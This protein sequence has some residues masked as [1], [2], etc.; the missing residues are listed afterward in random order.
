MLLEEVVKKTSLKT[1]VTQKST[2][3]TIQAFL[4][5]IKEA[6][7]D[8]DKVKL[9]GFGCFETRMTKEHRG[10]FNKKPTLILAHR[11]VKFT[12][13]EIFKEIV[14]KDTE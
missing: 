7:E 11:V 9:A 4:E 13:S 8:G 5:V 2:K 3:P 14:K 6:L 10:V 12:P 1:G